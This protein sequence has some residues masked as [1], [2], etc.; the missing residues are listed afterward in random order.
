VLAL[1][2]ADHDLMVDRAA[3]LEVRE[4]INPARVA[5]GSEPFAESAVPPEQEFYRRAFALGMARADH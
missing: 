4:W 3:Q 1:R 5:A 2:L